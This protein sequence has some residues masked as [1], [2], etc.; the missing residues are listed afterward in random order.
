MIIAN[1]SS[2]PPL[3]S[4]SS[5]NLSNG[6]AIPSHEVYYIRKKELLYNNDDA[7]RCIQRKPTLPGHPNVKLVHFRKFWENL[8]VVGQYWD[9]SLD[10]ST[11]SIEKKSTTSEHDAM[12]IDQPKA[13]GPPVSQATNDIN[14]QGQAECTYTGRRIS[15]GSKM[16]DQ[17]REDLVRTFL[18]TIIWALGCRI[19]NP[20]MLPRLKLQNLLIPV[21]HSAIVYRAPMDRQKSRQGI[22]EGPVMCVQCRSETTFEGN[23]GVADLLRETGAMLLVAQ[24]RAREGKE[25]VIPGKDK[26]WATMKRWGGGPGGEVGEVGEAPEGDIE[27][28]DEGPP[29]AK[30]G[31]R[32]SK[33]KTRAMEAYNKLQG[34]S[35]TWD[36]RVTY[37]Q[38][39]KSKKQS[40]D[41]IYMIS[42][43]NHHISIVRL[44]VHPEYLNYITNG[45]HC[46]DL[47]PMQRPWYILEMV[48]SKWFDLLLPDDRLQ[49]MRGIWGIMGFMMRT[50]ED[51]VEDE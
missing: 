20:R 40:Y 17:Y 33:A 18:E 39:G 34:P 4:P 19:E 47:D 46:R 38:I 43:L 49:A 26:W 11:L 41:D 10:G 45:E 15:T 14:V 50:L 9:T 24:E 22:L 21:R 44:R 32:Q 37:M 8:F 28:R 27:M 29:R 31:K 3:S 13:V 36:K 2:V 7:Y 30:R 12:D 6:A 48:R 16:P 25:E 1:D 51:E 23:T 35:P 42:S 5:K